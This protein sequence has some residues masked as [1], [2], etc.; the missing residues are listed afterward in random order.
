MN[1]DQAKG[2]FDV[3]VGGA[4]RK[5]GKLTGDIKLQVER[6]AQQVKGKVENAWGKA[7]DV[8][9]EANQEA[10]VHHETRLEVE[11]EIDAEN[12]RRIEV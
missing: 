1:K 5:T 10:E 8:V 3:L 7:K 4:K 9:H 12:E 2:T 11:M 6:M